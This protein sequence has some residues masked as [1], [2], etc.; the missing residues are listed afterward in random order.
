MP[1][2][3][4]WNYTLLILKPGISYGSVVSFMSWPFNW[5]KLVC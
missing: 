4:E 5:K 3:A 2:R 1:Y